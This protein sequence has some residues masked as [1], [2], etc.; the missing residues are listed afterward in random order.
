MSH[1][2]QTAG[3]LSVLLVSSLLICIFSSWRFLV[4]C[5]FFEFVLNAQLPVYF[6]FHLHSLSLSLYFQPG[7]VSF[8]FPSQ[9][10]SNCPSYLLFVS[11]RTFSSLRQRSRTLNASFSEAD[12]SLTLHWSFCYSKELCCIDTELPPLTPRLPENESN[13]PPWKLL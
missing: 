10:F 8:F 6:Y 5:L 9:L 1:P 4:I 12:W 2:E 3:S 7:E 11:T 13:V